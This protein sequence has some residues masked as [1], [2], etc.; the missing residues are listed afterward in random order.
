MFSCKVVDEE[1]EAL[2][3]GSKD[4]KLTESA[5]RKEGDTID[6]RLVNRLKTS[7]QN[8]IQ[9]WEYICWRTGFKHIMRRNEPDTSE[10]EFQE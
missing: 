4:V 10:A 2:I 9:R 3:I 1:S 8:R 5:E 7:I 6:K